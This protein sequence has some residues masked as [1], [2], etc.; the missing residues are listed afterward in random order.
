[1]GVHGCTCHG[2]TW[3]YMPWVYMGIHAMGVHAMSSGNPCT[4]LCGHVMSSGSSSLCRYACVCAVRVCYACVLCM[5][6]HLA[7]AFTGLHGHEGCELLRQ[8]AHV[9]LG[10][11]RDL[12]TVWQVCAY[13]H[14]HHMRMCTI[15]ACAPYTHVHHMRM[16]TTLWC[17][18]EV[19][20]Q[21]RSD[22][23]PDTLA[24]APRGWLS[25]III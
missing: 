13:V 4:C 21:M 12:G 9:L 18:E 16:C 1:M 3:V 8:L 20:I 25:L 14:V 24:A 5:H 7:A 6:M 17:R 22:L 10:I 11:G 15:C 23:R 2:C 19:A